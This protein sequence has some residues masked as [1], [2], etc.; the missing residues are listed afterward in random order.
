MHTFLDRENIVF[1]MDT[2][3]IQ[4]GC[5]G[6]IMIDAPLHTRNILMMRRF[7]QPTDHQTITTSNTFFFWFSYI[8][9]PDR[10]SK[11]GPGQNYCSNDIRRIPDGDQG[12]SSICATMRLSCDAQQS[13]A[14]SKPKWVRCV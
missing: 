2:A 10:P 5:S 4:A 13:I 7:P 1:N 11:S 6:A 8:W 3:Y 14:R 12:S 9:L